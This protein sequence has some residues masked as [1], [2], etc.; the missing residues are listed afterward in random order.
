MQNSS[1]LNVKGKCHTEYDVTREQYL[2]LPDFFI[3]CV[4]FLR[5]TYAHNSSCFKQKLEISQ[6]N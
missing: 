4:F 5:V 3:S 1:V 2:P 6:A